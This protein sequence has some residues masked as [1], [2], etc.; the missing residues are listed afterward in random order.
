MLVNRV[1][2]LHRRSP[3]SGGGR[4]S[5]EGHR[6]YPDE[7]PLSATVAMPRTVVGNQ[8]RFELRMGFSRGLNEVTLCKTSQLASIFHVKLRNIFVKPAKIAD[9]HK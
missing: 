5:R 6:A 7:V 3:P 4:G 8:V 1:P 2:R 9:L